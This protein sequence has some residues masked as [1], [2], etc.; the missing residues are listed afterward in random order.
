MTT[1][2]TTT[3][4]TTTSVPNLFVELLDAVY[5]AARSEGDTP[6][7]QERARKAV[8]AY[9]R[10]AGISAEAYASAVLARQ[11]RGYV[12]ALAMMAPSGA[13]ELFEQVLEQ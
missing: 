6:S 11:G 2:T 3:N 7:I 9:C 1:A 5:A 12:L 4:S 8:A 13:K 10:A